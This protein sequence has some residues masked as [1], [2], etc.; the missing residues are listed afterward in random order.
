MNPKTNSDVCTLLTKGYFSQAKDKIH[1]TNVDINQTDENKRTPLILCAFIEDPSWGLSLA[2][3]FLELGAEIN[4]CDTKQLNAVH[5][6]VVLERVE[7]LKLLLESVDFNINNGDCHGNSPLIYA[8]II[9]NEIITDMLIEYYQRYKIDI[10]RTNSSGINAFMQACLRGEL[11]V[12]RKL[13][14]LGADKS[15]RDRHGK[16]SW[17]YRDDAV[18]RVE[19]ADSHRQ[20]RI[21]KFADAER[22]GKSGQLESTQKFPDI[23]DQ[24]TEWNNQIR[25]GLKRIKRHKIDTYYV[26]GA[27]TGNSLEISGCMPINDNWKIRQIRPQTAMS[28]S[29][30]LLSRNDWYSFLGPLYISL[31]QQYST[32]FKN[33]T[34]S[35]FPTNDSSSCMNGKSKGRPRRL[36]RSLGSQSRRTSI[37]G[38]GN[39]ADE[40]SVNGANVGGKSRKKLEAVVSAKT[41]GRHLSKM[42]SNNLVP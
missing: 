29:R 19:F 18:A 7:L 1:T 15:I 21:V 37:S 23:V 28:T 33:F 34:K 39:A 3:L 5:Y 17:S 36:S 27:K 25:A 41:T 12:M 30:A 11:D 4:K 40:A 38:R 13:E 42:S 35:D 14:L 8:I 9:A 6:C 2:Q 16:S 31:E 32:S 10:D 24:N 26:A 22:V 20:L